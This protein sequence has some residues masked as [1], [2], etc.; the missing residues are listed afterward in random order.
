MV[1]IARKEIVI[2]IT[3]ISSGPFPDELL[4]HSDQVISSR[5]FV[6]SQ[7]VKIYTGCGTTSYCFEK[8]WVKQ[9]LLV[10]QV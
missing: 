6:F 9:V 7:T 3:V 10:S 8:Y 4:L 1:K 5:L 2:C